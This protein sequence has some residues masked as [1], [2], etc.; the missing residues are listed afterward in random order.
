VYIQIKSVGLLPDSI[1]E[2]LGG[3]V[4]TLAIEQAGDL[5]P[6]VTRAWLYTSSKDHPHALPNCDP[7]AF[8]TFATREQGAP[9]MPSADRLGSCSRPIESGMS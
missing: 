4:L 8:T 9:L 5:R 3:S 1:G 7:R 2:R 6:D